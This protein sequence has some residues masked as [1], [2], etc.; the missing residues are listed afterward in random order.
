MRIIDVEY[1]SNN[2]DKMPVFEHPRTYILIK[3]SLNYSAC[4]LLNIIIVIDTLIWNWLK[5]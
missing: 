1:R 2:H 4:L 5:N 3:N